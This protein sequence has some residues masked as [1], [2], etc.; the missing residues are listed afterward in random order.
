MRKWIKRFLAFAGIA[1]AALFAA[2]FLGGR[3]AA[4]K[5]LSKE[6]SVGSGTLRLVGPRFRWS[7]DLKADSVLYRGPGLSLAAGRT[8]IFADAF[9]SLLHFSPSVALRVDTLSLRLLPDSTRRDTS[10][11]LPDSIPFPDFRIP[12]AVR[13]HVARIKVF[14]TAGALVL[15]DGLELRTRG[16]QA[17]SLSIREIKARRTG[18]LR[19]SVSASV[20]WADSA[21]VLA[22]LSWRRSGDSLILDAHARK[23]NLLR[24]AAHVR[25]HLG[26]SKPYAKAMQ[27]PPSLPAVEGL[28][29]D[30][31]LSMDRT[32]GLQGEVRTSVSGF[33]A[34]LPMKPGPQR[35]AARIGFKDSAGTWS[36]Q[37]RGASG[38]DV[39]LKGTLFSTAT[40]SL[41]NPAWL[42]GH[43][44]LT[45]SGHLRGFNVVAGGKRGRADLD[46]AELRASRESLRADLATG[47]GSR[48]LADL[49]PGAS[50]RSGAGRSRASAGSES[51]R[52]A[53]VTQSGIAGWQGSFSA[54]IAP[55]ERWL[56]AF[57]D[58]NVS[59]RSLRAQGK[60][61]G[62]EVSAE[63]SAD[64]LRA[65][66]VLADSLRLYGRYGKS[67]FELEPSRLYWRDA[68]WSLSGRV[69]TG[70]A[71]PPMSLRLANP[72]YG[73]AE[74]AAP[75]PDRYEA[76]IANLAL[77]RLPYKG[78]DTLAANR[79]RVTAF[80][81]WDKR[82]RSGSA[83]LDA[84]GRYR[85]ESL[86]A[87]A[88]AEWDS[89]RLSIRDVH[90]ALAGNALSASAVVRLRGG[91]FYELK[92]LRKE[93]VQEASLAADRFDLA[94]AL[95][96][97][98]PQP[99]LRSGTASGRFEYT[100]SA[101]F[102]G[103]Y[104]LENLHLD[105]ADERFSIS[106]LALAGRGDT[107]TIRAAT[108]SEEEP[109]L[110]DTLDAAVTGVL[111]DT[112][113]LS[114]AAKVDTAIFLDFRGTVKDFR[115]LQGRLDVRGSL[116]LPQASGE[117]K[118]VDLRADIAVP[119]KDGLKGLRVQADT[120]L[121]TYAV[122]GLDTQRISAPVR[123]EGGKITIPELS[124]KAKSGAELR[125]RAEYD[126]ASR[127]LLADISG[128]RLAAQ[129]G[130]GDKVLLRE[131]RV[132]AQSDS[133]QLTVQAAVGSGSIEHVK[134]PLR[135]T[136]DFSRLTL[137][138]RAPLGSRAASGPGA[139][140]P[141][142]R[143][144][145][146]LDSSLVRYR[147]RSLVSLSGIFKKS[148]GQRRAAV[149]RTKPIQVQ[150][151]L[152]TSGRG[153][154]IDA[155]VVRLS[156]VGNMSVSGT[157]PYVLVQG[158]VTS[159][160]GSLG[161][162]KQ[163]YTIR[164]MEVKWLNAPLEE[165]EIA[166]EAEKRLARTCDAETKDSCNIKMD[167]TG[168]LNDIRFAYDSDCRG[169]YGSGSADV[170]AL[171]FSVPRGCYSP[172]AGSGT[173]GLS[174]REQALGLLD[175]VASNYI[176]Q[177]AEKVSAKWIASVQ[178]TGLGALAPNR[179][180]S[181]N[182]DSSASARDAIGLEVLSKKFWRLRLR[183]ASA[184]SLQNSDLASPFTYRVGLEWQPPLFR[185]VE[186]PAWRE[187]IKNTVTVDASVFTDPSRDPNSQQDPLLRRLGLSYNYDWWGYWWEKGGAAPGSAS[188]EAET[189]AAPPQGA[190]SAE[191]EIR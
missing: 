62:G 152:E 180:P 137:F 108:V 54:A 8:L 109:F 3:W 112:Q 34:S 185:L 148:G 181:A 22:N 43:L 57:T 166:L 131:L 83:E 183:A 135:A 42:A 173:A 123:M 168:P 73:S 29:A 159:Q 87:R 143:A 104:R 155:D 164:D 74:A 122:E 58:T 189:P 114:V 53:K 15:C 64:G 82:A 85:N 47:D 144:N 147:L 95:S 134:S 65:Y 161:L 97:A 118:D 66:G 30:I 11:A 96:V 191:G 18:P 46:V 44:G 179:Q 4:Q 24:A 172:Q 48:I 105:T 153:N 9:K 40:D 182:A 129:F 133:T 165:G 80:F 132:Q 60:A 103:R 72:D 25:A 158:R 37:S 12:A 163:A 5:Y 187:R 81:R 151:G 101:G 39:D 90:A 93:D 17:L 89:Q 138:Y 141:L 51:K 177:A 140:P 186:D 75:G 156:Y 6:V 13:A 71:G 99:P 1:G 16:P 20:F 170:A 31:G 149:R 63:V 86:Q 128:G 110:R 136:A 21:R 115:D 56:I 27:L 117:L 127:R 45:A 139:Q 111:G 32:F 7:L 49:R 145:V 116:T 35:I 10:K 26:S 184:Y 176:S 106:E 120:L 169:G 59:F 126:P 92:G 142:L 36:V 119:F 70:K 91:Q 150:I 171:V 167:L 107:L 79:P 55:G 121:A 125:G 50:G 154:A 52:N 69:E 130:A 84:Q 23:A 88:R 41:A 98:M 38:E 19:H 113:T 33:P 28:D 94:K 2:V 124:L 188:R 162:K 160:E 157:Y 78:L 68:E 175:P 61:N 102:S 67:S 178:V 14:D 146:V 190:K 76:R 100:D 77:D 174:Y